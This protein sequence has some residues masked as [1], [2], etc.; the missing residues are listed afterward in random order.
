MTTQNINAQQLDGQQYVIKWGDTLWGIS[1]ATGI[2]IEK[3]AYDN[4]IQNIDLIFADDVLI[5]NVMVMY[6]QVIMLLVMVTVVYIL[7][8]LST[9]IMAII[10]E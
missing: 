10:T 9:T 2:S 8:L 6:Q 7:R 4:N 1:Q 3:L 5:L